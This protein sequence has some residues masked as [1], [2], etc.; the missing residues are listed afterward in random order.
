MVTREMG[1]AGYINKWRYI[2]THTK[3]CGTQYNSVI[4]KATIY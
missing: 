4:T 1:S 2:K 3:V